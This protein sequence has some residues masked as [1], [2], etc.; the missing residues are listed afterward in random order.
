MAPGLLVDDMCAAA[1]QPFAQDNA[2]HPGRHKV[3]NIPAARRQGA[4][5]RAG[6]FQHR[7]GRENN[8]GPLCLKRLRGGRKGGPVAVFPAVHHKRRKAQ[9]L[10]PAPPLAKRKQHVAAKAQVQPRA[11]K[12]IF[13]HAKRIYRIIPAALAQLPPAHLHTG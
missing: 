3:R 4:H 11:R 13:Q 9:Y 8:L 5:L 1:V 2:P 10:A 7:A 12:G 6:Y